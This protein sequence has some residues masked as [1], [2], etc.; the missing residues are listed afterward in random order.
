MKPDS[1]TQRLSLTRTAA[2]KPRHGDRLIGIVDRIVH[3]WLGLLPQNSA[4]RFQRDLGRLKRLL[5]FYGSTD[6]L[7]RLT[8]RRSGRQQLVHAISTARVPGVGVMFLDINRFKWINDRLGHDAGDLVL[9]TVGSMLRTA[10]R[11]GDLAI[12]W[13]GEEFLIVLLSANGWDEFNTA[14]SRILRYIHDYDAQVAHGSMLPERISFAAG[15]VWLEWPPNRRRV[16]LGAH[17]IDKIVRVAD[18]GMY[19]S[20][21]EF[22]DNQNL[23]LP[24]KNLRL[25]NDEPTV[26]TSTEMLVEVSR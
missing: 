23:L 2:T 15:G 9:S 8:N 13:G 4:V 22:K 6:P 16:G 11:E 19:R 10:V 25:I 1:E 18:E 24:S 12:R 17:I 26:F 7:T 21:A 20:K 5:V 14:F 3:R